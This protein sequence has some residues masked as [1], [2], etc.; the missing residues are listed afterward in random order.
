MLPDV[1]GPR[2]DAAAAADHHHGLS[3]TAGDDGKLRNHERLY[4][5]IRMMNDATT[6][7]TPKLV[8]VSPC[9]SAVY[10]ITRIV[11]NSPCQ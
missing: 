7:T 5:V 4:S 6:H 1:T 3:H 9:A 10:D 8:R 11:T 2:D